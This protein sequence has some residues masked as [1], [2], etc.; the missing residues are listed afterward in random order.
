M[1]L[2][3]A[4]FAPVTLDAADLH[5]R[6]NTG[7]H[8]GAYG[9]ND[10][11]TPTEAQAQA[12]TYKMGRVTVQGLRIAIEQPNGSVRTGK[13]AGGKE[14]SSR[15]AAHYGYFEATRGA[16]GD[17]IDCFVGP[18]PESETAFL[19]NQRNKGGGFDEHKVMLGFMSERHARGAYLDSYERG[20]AGLQS[21]VPL[22]IPQLRWWIKHGNKRIALTAESLPLEASKPMTT[23]KINWTDTQPDGVSY[24]QV[25]YELRRMDGPDGLLLDSVTMAEI[26][27]DT[28]GVI[29]LDALVV[30]NAQLARMSERLR[31]IMDR[32]GGAVK[33]P[34]VQVSDPFRARGVTNIA[35][36]FELSDGQS[37]S[38]FFHNPDTAPNKLAPGD[39]MISW[40]WLLNKKD[41][42]I[43]VAPERGKDLNPR[44]VAQR[45]MKLAEKNSPAFQ[46]AN[47]KRAER[48]GNIEA[49]RGRIAE[50]E[51]TLNEL[52]A[53][54]EAARLEKDQR[55]IAAEDEARKTSYL[56]IED[57]SD[58]QLQYAREGLQGLYAG[59]HLAY[60]VAN[61]KNPSM[62]SSG[63]GYWLRKD[64]GAKPTELVYGFDE[65]DGEMVRRAA[66]E[67]VEPWKTVDPT[68]PEG[69]AMVMAAG[70]E[71]QR[72][73]AQNDLDGHFQKR[74]L[75]FS[76]ALSGLGWE[77]APGGLY[78]KGGYSVMPR[79]MTFVAN[80][81]NV[82]YGMKIAIY[83]GEKR[84]KIIDDDLSKTPAEIAAEIDAAVPAAEQTPAQ[85]V[86]AAYQFANATDAFKVRVAE[87]IEKTDYSE[88]ASAKAMDMKAKELGAEIHWGMGAAL[89]A[90]H[91]MTKYK[92][93][94]GEKVKHAKTGD[95]LTVIRA[96]RPGG[97]VFVEELQDAVPPQDLLIKK[98]GGFEALD[99]VSRASKHKFKQGDKV[100][101]KKT[102]EVLTVIG[103]PRT[104]GYVFVEE[105]QDAVSVNDLLVEVSNQFVSLDGV[106]VA[107]LG[108]A[109]AYTDGSGKWHSYTMEAM[110]RKDDAA[111]RY[112]VK[113]ATEA[114]EAGEKMNN[115]KA[116]QYRDEAHYASM[117]MQRRRKGGKQVMDSVILDEVGDFQDA[118]VGKIMQG[119]ELKGRA[120]IS[121]NGKAMV[122][123][124]ESDEQRVE[125]KDEVTG[126]WFTALW[127]EDGGGRMVE[128]LL[129]LQAAPSDDFKP[130]DKWV[131]VSASEYRIVDLSGLEWTLR[132][133]GSKWITDGGEMFA[134]LIDAQKAVE[135]NIA[136][137][138]RTLA[139]EAASRAE[140]E[141]MAAAK[142]KEPTPPVE[143]Y[144]FKDASDEALG[145]L[146]I[147]AQNTATR[148]TYKTAV[149][150]EKSADTHGMAIR[151]EAVSTLPT[152]D[153]AT[154]GLFGD[155]DQGHIRGD[156]SYN[157][158]KLAQVY[159]REDGMAA[160]DY[161]KGLPEALGGAFDQFEDDYT[162]WN[163]AWDDVI[164]KLRNECDDRGFAQRPALEIFTEGLAKAGWSDSGT[165][166]YL[167]SEGGN[168]AIEMGK[169]HNEWHRATLKAWINGAWA[170]MPEVVT[171]DAREYV[172][173]PPNASEDEVGYA[174]S[175]LLEYAATLQAWA[176]ANQGGAE[177]EVAPIDRLGEP[178]HRNYRIQTRKGRARLNSSV[179][180]PPV[181]KVFTEVEMSALKK[182]VK[183]AGFSA[184]VEGGSIRV[185]GEDAQEIPDGMWL[186][187]TEKINEK[188]AIKA[189]EIATRDAAEAAEY[190]S[191]PSSKWIDEQMGLEFTNFFNRLKLARFLDGKDEK[192]NGL[193]NHKWSDALEK[194]VDISTPQ[195]VNEVLSK[196]KAAYLSQSTAPTPEPTVTPDPAPAA[197]AKDRA[198]F[199]SLIDG[200]YPDLD[201][202]EL[203]NNL[204][205]AYQRNSEDA[206]MVSLFTQAINAYTTAS[207]AE[208]EG[209]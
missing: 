17:G 109:P 30:E 69:Y 92:F 138:A 193:M 144:A 26:M 159:V 145:L 198:F 87:S 54:V 61:P 49:I 70:E 179:L 113:D 32:S 149:S 48:M 98:D 20:W 165:G 16:D 102:K 166:L 7:A 18:F 168:V 59:T 22:S 186:T 99:S 72:Y 151:W 160:F 188:Q 76:R 75:D 36:V 45:I 121:V 205:A 10:L 117:E 57:A 153:D 64:N 79:T 41:I 8:A 139:E 147:G 65:V 116:A 146:R 195:T 192:F 19:I 114:A 209:M 140:V 1:K 9:A 82:R 97:Y 53:Q 185:V 50:K 136:Q 119:G 101:H 155:G 204:E 108:H 167:K 6:I 104:G 74:Q 12:G 91:P 84:Q 150:V 133:K 190:A 126:K 164:Y 5:G 199:M 34:A 55:V 3:H 143:V 68:T 124:G 15:M 127:S 129:K 142:A 77:A 81:F 89:D 169:D 194:F 180:M 88:F 71:D 178:P 135:D 66:P 90:V 58:E 52:V 203:V 123:V 96:V 39:E 100:K 173:F 46:K 200:T 196:L 206:E 38:I 11:K 161:D 51:A 134:R 67:V 184:Y 148:S 154:G 21:M 176:D 85:R 60:F 207:L 35:T 175:N 80:G 27:E 174:L 197:N 137:S 141:A 187:K 29:A 172:D 62:V 177:P 125:F 28:D 44:L 110:K 183:D 40:K 47:T 95:I 106:S 33:V 94:K 42:T 128:Q 171:E 122:F 182:W 25:L 115:P 105:M 112:I 162:G 152:F 63:V 130:S 43:V 83:E 14:W 181:G 131:K 191:L 107:E 23:K 56:A 78:A 24:D 202:P 118:I 93:E 120:V 208:T 158:T 170:D 31:A 156:L 37:V 132:K 13:D 73:W 157:G 4:V 163:D 201:D 2:H 86:D 103:Q 189:Q 111:L